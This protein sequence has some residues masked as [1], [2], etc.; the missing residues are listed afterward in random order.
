MADRD[1][2][3]GD[4]LRDYGIDPD[5]GAEI[6]Q[7]SPGE[8]DP[9]L[10]E[11]PNRI[12]WIGLAAGLLAALLVYFV[13]PG[14]VA[15]AARLTAAV[16]VLMGVWWMTEALPIP[17]T[18]LVPLVVFPVLGDASV[19]DVGASYG[20]NIIFLFMGGFMLA[21][22]MQRWNLHRRIALVTVRAM[23]TN[24]AMV[25]AGFMI[26]TGFLSMWVSNTATAVMML[27]IG[28]SVLLLVARL[29]TATAA[30]GEDG[31]LDRVDADADPTSQE[32]KDAVIESNFGTA[33]MLGIAY[34]A[35]IGSLGTIIGTPPN[36]LLV[37]YLAEN[38]DITIGFGQWM[39]VGVPLAVIF[40][41]ICWF[42]LT[43]VFFKP[44]IDEIPG[45]REM[46]TKE[47]D[48]LGR[49]SQ[50]EIRVL[51]IFVL[52]AASWVSIPLLFD[53][54]PID[55]A[56]IA[57]TIA[58]LLFLLPAGAARGV[59]LLDWNSAVALPWGVLL[60]FGGGL[61][62][63]A[64]FGSS[65]LT[66]WI[67]T[68]AEGLGGLPMV[69]LVVIF[70]AGIIFLTE[71][72]SNTATAATFLPVAGGVALGL[73]VDPMLLAIPVALAATCAFMLPVATPPNAIAFGSGYVTIPQMVKAGLWLNLIGIVLVT[74][75]VMTL[76]VWV[77]SIVY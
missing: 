63:S 66:E 73:G 14:D 67:G 36:T 59:R 37:G 13:M 53:E 12:R 7:Q 32:V 2:V 46:M 31:A 39:M 38:H 27:P 35:S 77:F 16:A 65:G 68:Q 23:G 4:Y 44:E 21:L 60:L 55:D 41:A 58:I 17:V 57:M 43:K 18:A 29:G 28:V 24:P 20:N 72:T 34:A 25:V 33:L 61:A 70:T 51:A 52:A 54:P 19:N 3:Q 8:R 56:G 50:G 10:E 15:H 11:R 26:A 42:L 22:A 5:R 9:G 49:M 40:L 1:P 6:E 62:L 76:A 45:G 30:A 48:K 47:I 69:L 71:L 74:A 75:T 64:Q